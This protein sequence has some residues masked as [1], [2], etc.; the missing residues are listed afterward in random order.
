[1]KKKLA[2]GIRKHI[3]REKARIRRDIFDVKEQKRLIDELYMKFIPG[4]QKEIQE[5]P[6]AQKQETKEFVADSTGRK[7]PVEKKKKARKSTTVTVKP[8]TKI[9]KAT[10]QKKN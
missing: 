8:K 10:K 2:R 9:V 5:K 4:A 3:R 7:K 6:E 1:M